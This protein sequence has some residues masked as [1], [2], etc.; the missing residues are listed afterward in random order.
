[1]R[2]SRNRRR[3]CPAAGFAVGAALGSGPGAARLRHRG[4]AGSAGGAGARVAAHRAV[5]SCA[6][7]SR[8]TRKAGR[9]SAR[10]SASPTSTSP[11]RRVAAARTPLRM[12]DGCRDGTPSRSSSSSSRGRARASRMR[13][14]SPSP[15]PTPR[16]ALRAHGPAQGGGRDGLRFLHELREPQGQG[17]GRQSARRAL[18]LLADHRSSGPGRGRRGARD[19][20]RIGD[21]LRDPSAREPA[22]GLGLA[23]EPAPG[24]GRSAAR[25]VRADGRAVRRTARP[26]SARLGRLPHAPAAGRVLARG[27][28]PPARPHPLHARRRRLDGRTAVP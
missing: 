13:R 15:P 23:P 9:R 21:L 17:A 8:R 28:A 6:S 5:L 10:R 19:R 3:P 18:L 2:E 4:L 12:R 26:A 14:R 1:M 27:R 20:G 25:G 11:R 24:L 22:R 7:G 16:G